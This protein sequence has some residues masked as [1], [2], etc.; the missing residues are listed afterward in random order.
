MSL[1]PAADDAR[2]RGADRLCHA[3]GDL[4]RRHGAPPD[5]AEP[6][7]AGAKPSRS[8]VRRSS[9]APGRAEQPAVASTEISDRLSVRSPRIASRIVDGRTV[10][11]PFTRRS[12]RRRAGR[13]PRP[14][15]RAT[16]A[17]AIETSPSR[18]DHVTA[19]E[20]HDREERGSRPARPKITTRRFQVRCAPVG[21]RAE[22]V[23]EL[24]EAALGRAPAAAESGRADR[25]SRSRSAARAARS[26]RRRAS[27][28]AAR[29]RA[30]ERGAS[31][32]PA[33]SAVEVATAPACASP[34][35]SRSRRAGSRRCRTRSR[36]A[37][38]SASA[39]GKPM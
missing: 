1:R 12:C 21:V 17:D 13:P 23:V 29:R 15:A 4:D 39:G 26:L 9:A 31:R 35:S 27:A 28:S 11:L 7:A 22:R 24:L 37:S 33:R 19:R 5:G 3:P 6:L 10:A 8:A 38:S 20:E 16:S 14:A 18:P 36:C 34:G 32:A 2:E 30:A 25:S